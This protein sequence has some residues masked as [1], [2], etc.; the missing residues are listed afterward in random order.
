MDTTPDPPEPTIPSSLS[1]FNNPQIENTAENLLRYWAAVGTATASVSID[2]VP[3]RDDE[4][5]TDPEDEQRFLLNCW[6][7]ITAHDEHLLLSALREA[8]P[9]KADEIADRLIVSAEAGDSYGEWLW[10]WATESGLDAQA[11][12]D[13][14]RANLTAQREARGG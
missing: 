11:I 4:G 7:T 6:Q 8:D 1:P 5:N 10:Q 9:A 12:D 2:L 13:E 14:A 3:P